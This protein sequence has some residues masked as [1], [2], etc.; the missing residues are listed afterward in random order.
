MAVPEATRLDK[1][2]A[3]TEAVPRA[4]ILRQT[5]TSKTASDSHRLA[6]TKPVLLLLAA[7]VLTQPQQTQPQFRHPRRMRRR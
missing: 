1:G 7:K 6:S 2:D 3:S 5:Q 4:L